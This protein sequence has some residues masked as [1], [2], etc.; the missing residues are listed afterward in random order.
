M[1]LQKMTC[2]RFMGGSMNLYYLLKSS[3]W[4]WDIITYRAKDWVGK[5]I[6][7]QVKLSMGKEGFRLRRKIKV[8]FM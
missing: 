2:L 8:L 1:R 4:R 5:L 3:I 6:I 7:Y